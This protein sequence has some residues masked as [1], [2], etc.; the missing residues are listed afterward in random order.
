MNVLTA[1]LGILHD[2]LLSHAF[3]LGVIPF[4]GGSYLAYGI[5]DNSVA[6]S[7]GDLTPTYVFISGCLAAA[8][9]K[10]ILKYKVIKTQYYSFYFRNQGIFPL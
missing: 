10:V 6:N 2:I 5:L 3:F 1:E 9:A 8:V 4:A 7:P